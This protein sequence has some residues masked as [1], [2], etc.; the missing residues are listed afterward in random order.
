MKLIVGLGN[1]GNQYAGT[2]HNVGFDVIDR[3]AWRNGLTS[4][5]DDF[6][7]VSR[8][9][10]DGLALDGSVSVAGGGSEK[11]LL[12]KP[13]T[14]M[15]LSGRA[16]Q[17]AMAFYQLTPVDVMI[18]LD[19]VALPCGKLRIRPGGSDGGHNGLKDIARALGTQQYPRLR[20]GVDAPPPRVPQR[21]YVLGRFTESQRQ[22]IDLDRAA[23]ALL[24]WIG[25]GLNAAMNEYNVSEKE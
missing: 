24:M 8:M 1:P 3:F 13:T 19:D 14:F 7:R 6:D 18:V 11:V 17:A 10:F 4:S 12:L 23:E 15:N 22:K 2:R 5:S 20:V 25:K 16:V 21:D 9:K